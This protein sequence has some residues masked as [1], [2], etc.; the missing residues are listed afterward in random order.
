MSNVTNVDI[1]LLDLMYKRAE[2]GPHCRK[3]LSPCEYVV[4]VCIYELSTHVPVVWSATCFQN[5]VTDIKRYF[6]YE[7]IFFS[8]ILEV[9][10]VPVFIRLARLF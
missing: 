3:R 1:P 6:K 4:D 10:P 9:S 5:L 7:K 8:V 2:T